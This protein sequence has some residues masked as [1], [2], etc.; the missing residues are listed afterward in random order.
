MA[1]FTIKHHIK[2]NDNGKMLREFLTE[3]GV[4]RRALTAIKFRGGSIQVNGTP[5]NVRYI[6]RESDVLEVVFPQELPSESLSSESL[7]LDIV[8]ED[9]DIIVIDKPPYMNT[10][11]SREHPNGSLAN[12][13]MHHYRRSGVVA[14][15]HIV[16]RLDRNTS[17]LVLAAKHRH[18]HHIL[19]Q[20]QRES[21]L[22]REYEGLAE[23]CLQDNEGTIDA[24]IGRKE[25]SIIEREVR[26]DGKKA[27]THY[28]VLDQYK[29][30]AHIRLKLE[31]GRT[32]QIRVHMAFLGHPLLGDGLYGG[33]KDLIGR[34][35]LHCSRIQFIH[36]L[37]KDQ[38][39]FHSQL[40][41]DLSR[42]LSEGGR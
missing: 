12:G 21:E 9:S 29:E 38:M 6:L 24:P 10:I 8:Y 13:L 42:L 35:A 1:P 19:G 3:Q 7:S 11:P 28:E 16:T 26:E 5:V 4:S 36:P 30:Y 39:V 25:T 15:P 31:T 40:P 20:M 27:I 2:K 14:S 41:G 37:S 17:G 18:A 23:G 34:Q 22:G 33:R 32:H